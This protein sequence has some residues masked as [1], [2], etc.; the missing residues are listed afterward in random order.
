VRAMACNSDGKSGDSK[1][2]PK[3]LRSSR[4]HAP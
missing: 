1:R 2:C 3:A 4:F